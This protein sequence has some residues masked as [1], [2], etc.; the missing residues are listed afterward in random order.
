MSAST[1]GSRT[2]YRSVGVSLLVHAAVVLIPASWLALGAGKP[3]SPFLSSGGVPVSFFVEAPEAAP[4]S[5]TQQA[6]P[7]SPVPPVASPT[8][9]FGGALPP[10]AGSVP[11]AGAPR[12]G[13]PAPA[14][15]EGAPS[16]PDAAYRPPRLL[17]GAL[18]VPGEHL[19]I[20]VEVHVDT[21]GNVAGVEILT[22]G[23]PPEVEDAVRRAASAMRF[24]PARRGDQP[25]DSWFPVEFRN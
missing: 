3:R 7:E 5:G 4:S 14:L 25:V 8:D 11:A 16:G 19:R 24:V 15:P 17:V 9:P 10:A 22:P 23:L 20:Q 1:S 18:T 2:W 13:A 12:P 21:E 6:V